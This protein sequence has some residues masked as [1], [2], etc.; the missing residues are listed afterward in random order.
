M[1]MH[2][3]RDDVQVEMFI[4][5]KDL[6]STI[7]CVRLWQ[8]SKNKLVKNYQLNNSAIICNELIIWFNGSVKCLGKIFT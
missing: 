6:Y 3:Y 2:Q 4:L 7:S 5:Q 8:N 1:F